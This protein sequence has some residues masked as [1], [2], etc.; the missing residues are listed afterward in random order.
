MATGDNEPS[1]FAVYIEE[2]P[3]PIEETT[4]PRRKRANSKARLK[5][6]LTDV[7]ANGPAPTAIVYQRGAAH[8]FTKKQLWDIRE[9]MRIV[10]FKETGIPRG[11]WFLALPEHV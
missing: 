5:I 3:A 1:V 11:R 2:T 7:L 6:L 10:A 9:K 4:G 8:G